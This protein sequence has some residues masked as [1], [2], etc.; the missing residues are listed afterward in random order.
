MTDPKKIQQLYLRAM[1][2]GLPKL[3][4]SEE[5]AFFVNQYSESRLAI[6]RA[7]R[8]R[9]LRSVLHDDMRLLSKV[10]DKAKLLPY[11]QE[12]VA[13]ECFWMHRG[14][15]LIEDFSIFFVDHTIAPLHIKVLARIEGVYSGLSASVHADTPWVAHDK[16]KDG[17]DTVE[18][19]RA[20]FALS[21]PKMFDSL[22]D[23]EPEPLEVNCVIRRTQR[24]IHVKFHR[25]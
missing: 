12:Y 5:E 4:G 24:K 20:P 11:V 21:F 17:E 23:Y 19:F 9:N 6:E 22:Q 3:I 15:T 2:S 25:I 8:V 13:S 10:L 7:A 1:Y 16:W 14:R 18:S